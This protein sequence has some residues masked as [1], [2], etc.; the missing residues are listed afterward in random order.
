M[1]HPAPFLLQLRRKIRIFTDRLM[2]EYYGIGT[3]ISGPLRHA[4]ECEDHL[5]ARA[6]VPEE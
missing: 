4:V 2:D 6:M 5:L 1:S 3:T